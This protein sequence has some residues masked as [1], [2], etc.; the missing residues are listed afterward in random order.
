[1]DV[2]G[3][4][5]AIDAEGDAPPADGRVGLARRAWDA[6]LLV[7]LAALLVLTIAIA[8][9]AT[10]VGMMV[11]DDGSYELQ[12]RALEEG[13]W[14]Y[15]AGTADLDPTGDHYPIV[16]VE[17]GDG[18]WMPSAKHPAWPW[19]GH[20]VA[21]VTGAGAAYL[22]ISIA[23]V[24][25]LATM[26]WILASEHERRLARPAFW[27][28][29]TAPVA[30]SAGVPW[31]HTPAAATAAVAT[32]AVVRLA[33]RPAAWVALVGAGSLAATVLL[34]AE[35][36]LLAIALAI[37]LGVGLRRGG[38]R[39]GAVVGWSA[40]VV[41]FGALV[42]RLEAAWIA[43]I[44]GAGS[45][46]VVARTSQGG[47]EA[48]GFVAGR[49]HAT[50]RSLVDGASP[51]RNVAMAVVVVATAVAAAL[52]AR[53]NV[54]MVRL[55]Q[56]SAGV[57]LLLLAERLRWLP[58]FAVTGMAT[59][60]PIVVTGLAGAAWTA[61][62]R[63]PVELAIAASFVGAVLATQYTDGGAG[64]WGARF[65]WV[66]TAPLVVVAV[67]G[68]A[69][70]DAVA[71][72]VTSGSI[73]TARRMLIALVVV[74]VLLGVTTIAKVHDSTDELF[75][76]VD[77]AIQGIAITPTGE[78]PRM[79]WRHDVDWLLVDDEDTVEDLVEVL[80]DLGRAGVDRASLVLL[81]ED[82]DEAEVAVGTSDGW[83]EQ[84]REDLGELTVVVLQR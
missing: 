82:L 17:G 6:P 13:S 56:A 78:L 44:S 30:L 80:D 59:T 2:M 24:L 35:G 66:G 75:S 33:S 32:W 31:A 52:V 11:A 63:V 46:T 15:D 25:L 28:A 10:S 22:V 65:F 14:A 45:T 16:N 23:A 34:R 49:F 53:G 7:H 12:L 74:P 38:R 1:M 3:P 40:A 79:M 26:A 18:R 61:W 62:R 29:G 37:G 69:R 72:P 19:L 67:V 51:S 55:W 81:Q 36:L 54:R 73:F 57:A 5:A 47:V 77:G 41:A 4:A 27:L 42:V 84:E 8:S 83:Q 64:S 50:L 70:I 39:W 68:L 76:G 71:T 60:W 58:D 48:D 21:R 43:S 9:F 20:Q